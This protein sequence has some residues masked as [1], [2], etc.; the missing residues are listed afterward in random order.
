MKDA[1]VI[2]S[3]LMMLG[4]VAIGVLWK[5][6]NVHKQRM[7][8]QIAA[9]APEPPDWESIERKGDILTIVDRDRSVI[10]LRCKQILGARHWYPG[11]HPEGRPWNAV[12]I[13]FGPGRMRM[14]CKEAEDAEKIME[15][16]FQ[17]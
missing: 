14:D 13:Q 11:Q 6:D 7:A 9:N 16:M 12:E 1:F 10:K 8:A 15:L 2:L 5:M 17:E 3:T 4:A